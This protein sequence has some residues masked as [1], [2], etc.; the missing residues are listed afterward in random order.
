MQ[1]AKRLAS[2][3]SVVAVAAALAACGGG[4][5]ADGPVTITFS[6]W[7]FAEP[8]RGDALKKVVADFNASQT[9]VKVDT[10]SIPYPRYAETVTTQLG[11]R[12]GPDVLNFDHDVWVLAQ[13]SRFLSD[14]TDKVKA[15]SAGFVEADRT[16]FVDGK[17]YGIVWETLNY[18]LIMNEELLAQAGVQPPTNYDEFAAAAK[19]LTKGDQ[20]F[21]FAFRNTMPEQTG[22]WFDLSNW[23]YGNGGRW[24]DDSGKPTVNSPQVVKGVTQYRD[25]FVNKYV[26]QGADAATY[27]RMFWEGKVAMTIDNNSVPTIFKTQNPKLKLKVVPNPFGADTNSMILEHVGVNRASKHQDAAV[28]FVNYLVEQTTQKKLSDALGGSG[29]GTKVD[30]SNLL[31]QKPWLET[32]DKVSTSGLVIAPK[33]AEDRT[34]EIRKAVL[35]EVDKVLRQSRDPQAAMADAQKAVEAVLK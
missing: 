14:L 12:S 1:I 33:G 27:R 26:P 31:P 6:N 30:R 21:G 2:A 17:R 16:N 7:Q 11:A 20:Q 29:L 23:V 19:T 24:T 4:D 13:K 22:W 25:F 5:S 32:Y 28:K 18:A 3:L 34:A 9:E 15:P 10:V 8:G 35:T